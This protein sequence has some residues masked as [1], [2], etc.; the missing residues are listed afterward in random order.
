M[1]RKNIYRNLRDFQKRGGGSLY[2]PEFNLS[3]QNNN[4]IKVIYNN[5]TNFNDIHYLIMEV[6][7]NFRKIEDMMFQ[8]KTDESIIKTIKNDKILY[9]GVIGEEPNYDTRVKINPINFNCI[10]FLIKNSKLFKRNE[11]KS[12]KY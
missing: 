8:L 9:L 7:L 2:F 1:P 10:I 11:Q 4:D 12:F 6:K 5:C 3:L